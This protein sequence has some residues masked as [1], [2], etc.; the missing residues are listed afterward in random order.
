M[1]FPYPILV[2]DI[3]GTNVRIA[4]V[5]EPGGNLGPVTKF[6]TADHAGFA[7]CVETAL[8]QTRAARPRSILAC[9]AGPVEQRRLHMTNAAWTID[10]PQIAYRLGLSQG[11]LFNDFEAQAL[12]LPAH[13]PDWLH[14][15]GDDLPR[16]PGPQIVLGPGTGLGVAAL[17]TN[18]GKY[19][20]L[21]SEAAHIEFA[22]ATDEDAGVWQ[23]LERF[24]GRITAETLVSGPGLA[25]L[26]AARAA[27]TGAELTVSTSAD[28]VHA[29]LRDPLGREADS[30]RHFWRLTGRFAGDMALVFLARNGVALSGGILPRI[31]SLLDAADFRSAFQSKAPMEHVLRKIPTWVVTAPDVVLAGLAA[32]AARPSAYEIDYHQRAWR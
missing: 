15:I 29:A 5:V 13:R 28:I 30:V 12:S 19:L 7:E 32:I 17:V 6:K 8:A 4:E 2:C 22:P 24:H 3:G 1:E 18:G 11:I 23:H 16:E 21:A 20:P 10:G 14:L 9:G 26:H 25:R 27:S 31:V